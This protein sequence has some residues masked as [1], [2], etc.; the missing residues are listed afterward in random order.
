MAADSNPVYRI[1][2]YCIFMHVSF[3]F[4]FT[5]VLYAWAIA[6]A[7]INNSQ[8]AV[9]L[10]GQTLSFLFDILYIELN[11]VTIPDVV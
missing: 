10:S 3:S 7:V 11:M 2:F 1:F 6:T 5:L 4:Y 9:R 8:A